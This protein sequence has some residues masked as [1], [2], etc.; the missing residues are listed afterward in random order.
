MEAFAAFTGCGSTGDT[1]EFS[2]FY[3][4][5]KF[6][7]NVFSSHFAAFYVIGSNKGS[8]G[9]FVGAAVQS[10][11][12]NLCFIGS[13]NRSGNGSRVNRV[14]QKYAYALLEQVCNVVSLFCRVVLGINDFYVNAKLFGFCFNAVFN[15]NKERVV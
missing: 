14:Y 1:F 11:Y 15:G 13:F 2:N 10:N 6:F 7:N 8:N 9:A 12:R 4:F 3:A 5:A